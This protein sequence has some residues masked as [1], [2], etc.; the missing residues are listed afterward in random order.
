MGPGPAGPPSDVSDA[1][2]AQGYPEFPPSPDSWLGDNTTPRYWKYSKSGDIKSKT[3]AQ[4]WILKTN[5]RRY[6][7]F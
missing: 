6:K 2:S 7:L 3:L 4:L 5:K 1:S